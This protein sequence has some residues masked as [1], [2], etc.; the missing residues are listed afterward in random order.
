MKLRLRWYV[1]LSAALLLL[2][3]AV[4]CRQGSAPERVPVTLPTASPTQAVKPLS[5]S[6]LMH[7]EEFSTQRQ[8][9]EQ[10]WDQFH[11]DFDA[12]RNGLTSCNRSSVEEAL[13]DFAVSF[14]G[15]TTRTR[16]LSRS[17]DTRE[18]AEILI[19]AAEAEETAYRQLRDH[20]Q[21]NVLSLFENVEIVRSESTG[22]QRTVEDTLEELRDE[23]EDLIDPQQMRNVEEFSAAFGPIFDAWTEFHDEYGIFLQISDDLSGELLAARIEALAEQFSDIIDDVRRLPDTKAVDEKAGMLLTGWQTPKLRP[24]RACLKR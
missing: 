20:W 19:A 9:I 4:A 3:S 15:I 13:Q 11:R 22:A 2:A 12:W 5:A 24:W 16:Y 1:L 23:L 14:N 6:D 8:I 18:P 17:E 7:L 10:D 21:P